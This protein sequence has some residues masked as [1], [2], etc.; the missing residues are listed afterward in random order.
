MLGQ[1][2]DFLAF[3]IAQKKQINLILNF[4]CLYLQLWK[5]AGMY[6]HIFF[7]YIFF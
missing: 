2:R 1:F 7:I 3:V 4:S 6:M 5:T